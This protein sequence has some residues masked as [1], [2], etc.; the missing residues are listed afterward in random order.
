MLNRHA[1]MNPLDGE[2]P[3][4][5]STCR[6]Q[7]G[8]NVTSLS[9]LPSDYFDLKAWPTRAIGL[10]MLVLA[11]PAIAILILIVRATSPGPGLYR[12]T[13]TGKGG[14]E[15]KMYKIRTMYQDAESLTGPTW[16][17]PGD[18]RITPVGRVM[19]LL[20]L[21]ELPQLI[22]I[23]NGEMDLI[24]PRPERPAF[25]E[26][27][28]REIPNYRERLQVLPGVTGLAQVNL[29]PDETLNCVRK[30]LTLDRDYINN[31][32]FSL[33]LRI[34]LCT[35]L[36]MLGIRHGRA[37]RWLRLERPVPDFAEATTRSIRSLE[38]RIEKPARKHQDAVCVGNRSHSDSLPNGVEDED[39]EDIYVGFVPEPVVSATPASR[40]PR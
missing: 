35:S 16:C 19:R 29:P 40:R 15:F 20:H 28:A 14:K 39:V 9:G 3:V 5:S 30:K 1:R 6:E 21:D 2:T 23:V 26:V 32:D 17:K 13:R 31:A 34:L 10:I 27:L 18:S 24:G 33:D 11:S 25:V 7:H 38:N 37:V 36:R 4:Q 12:Q 8:S 22:N